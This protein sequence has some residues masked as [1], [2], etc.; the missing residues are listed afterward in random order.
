MRILIICDLYLPVIGG[1]EFAV[2]NLAKQFKRKGHEVKIIASRH[3]VNLRGKEIID[4]I[5]I[6]RLYFPVPTTLRSMLMS[7][8]APF[9]LIKLIK[10]IKKWRPD[11]VNLYFLSENSLYTLAAK[12]LLGFKLVASA[13][14]N[15]IHKNP[16]KSALHRWFIRKILLTAEYVTGSSGSF[17]NDVK[18]FVPVNNS[19]VT[20]NGIN[21]E[22]FTSKR[23]YRHKRP[24][25]FSIGRFEY[26]KGFDMLIKAFSDV[27]I[28]NINLLIA[29]KGDEWQRCKELIKELGMGD[30]IKLLGYVN[31]EEKIKLYNGCEFFVLPSRA[32]PFGITNL[33]AMA[34][35]KAVLATAVNGVPEIVD[36]TRGMLMEPNVNSI[37]KGLQKMIRYRGKQQLG[38]NG[39]QFVEENYTW[40]KIADKYLD[41]FTKVLS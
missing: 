11:I 8:F 18:K 34:A 27:K 16:Y 13:Q 30:R 17:L 32:E 12:K 36:R 41:I 35:G 31:D 19:S 40:S 10:E 14:G 5:E 25:V 1:A 29:G 7:F 23:K 9:S 26:K 15:D 33:E 2:N 28:N 3:P 39:K 20:A 4:D 24:Y 38:R 21:V 22:D 6:K 37:V